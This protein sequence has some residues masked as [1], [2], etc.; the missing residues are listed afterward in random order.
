VWWHENL[1]AAIDTSGFCAFSAGALIADGIADLDM[2]AG[3]I[4]PPSLATGE[5]AGAAWLALGEELVRAQRSLNRAWGA[6]EDD[7][8]P[9]WARAQL[10]QPGMLD[11]YRALRDGRA[12]GASAESARPIRALEPAETGPRKSG[13][14]ELR[15]GGALARTLGP[16]RT[17][18]LALPARL[19][20][21]LRRAA[22]AN[23]A[24]AA[25]LARNGHAL[26]AVYR[27]GEKL[28]PSSLVA[29]G[30]RLDLVLVVSGG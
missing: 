20:E 19:D 23:P 16:S 22:E 5:R 15:A 25:L 26:P 17:V 13:K 18:E 14:V 3:A 29:D 10:D 8:R 24:A 21:V 1:A 9:E 6:T 30:E 12:L 4:G 11:E 2:L 28:S 7:E 27:N